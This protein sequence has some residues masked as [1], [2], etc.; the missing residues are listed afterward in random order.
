M[1]SEIVDQLEYLFNPR[2]VAVIGASNSFGKWG[3]GSFSRLLASGLKE[4]Y[5][6]NS[7]LSEVSGVKAYTSVTE[8]EGPIDFAV[9]AVPTPKVPDTLRECVAKGIKMGLIIT[10]GFKEASGGGEL[11]DEIIRIAKSGGMRF[12][13]PNSMGHIN[14]RNDFC[15]GPFIPRIES[16]HIGLIAQSGNV[17]TYIL[18][19]GIDMGIGFSKFVSSG[20][21]ADLH[22]ED[23]IE[24]LAQDKDTKVIACYIEG[25]RESQRFLE[26]AREITQQKPIVVLK[27]G[28]TYAGAK[29]ALSH[30]ASLAGSDVISDAAFRQAGIIRV[31]EVNE[32]LDVAAA[33]LNQPI[34]KGNRVGILSAGG[35]FGVIT[36]DACERYGLEVADLSADT[37]DKIDKVLPDRWPR[38]NPV[39]MVAG[40][41]ATYDC[42]SAL[43]EDDNFDA[44]LAINSV[45]ETRWWRLSFL[46]YVPDVLQKEAEAQVTAIDTEEL[47]KLNT[48]LKSM[49]K[50]NKPI[51]FSRVPGGKTESDI[52]EMLRQN[53]I[54]MYPTPERVVKVAS[55][56]VGYG[57][58]LNS[59]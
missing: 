32:L 36:A 42:L 45:E 48:M 54:P 12:V 18:Q 40:G 30:T 51:F 47:T 15:S 10:S 35:G 26:L 24:Y 3:S 13:G 41:F 27:S 9:I 49:Y 34:P 37:I 58:Y 25:L 11:E 43:L 14:A 23:Y 57:K 6:I 16:G 28:K 50:C 8:V 4:L 56:L 5:P 21:E 19:S 55:Y 22:I 29:A 20:N 59:H 52:V 7:T 44:I 39:D 33:L 31:N 38:S 1:N 53:D 17:G 46:E 2:S